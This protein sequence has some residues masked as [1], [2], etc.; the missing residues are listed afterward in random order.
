[1]MEGRFRMLGGLDVSRDPLGEYLSEFDSEAQVQVR[2]EAKVLGTKSSLLASSSSALCHL[3]SMFI[4][5]EFSL[6]MF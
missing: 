1:M 3:Y 6:R 5:R 2:M 4:C